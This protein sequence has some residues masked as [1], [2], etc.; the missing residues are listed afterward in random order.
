M[1]LFYVIANQLEKLQIFS[2]IRIVIIK[3]WSTLKRVQYIGCTF[4]HNH[5]LK[6]S[7]HLEKPVNNVNAYFTFQ[8][9]KSTLAYQGKNI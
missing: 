6:A 7:I 8:V 1:Q 4:S 5:V 2:S 3:N 9:I